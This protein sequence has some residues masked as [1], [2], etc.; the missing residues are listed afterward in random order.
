MGLSSQGAVQGD[1]GQRRQSAGGEVLIHCARA[2]LFAA[3]L[4]A[5]APALALSIPDHPDGPIND[6]AHVLSPEAK[7]RL[8]QQLLGYEQGTTRQIAVA[9]FPSL[10]DES[11]EDFTVRLAEKWK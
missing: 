7:A 3:L 10:D 1:H 8:E 11:M 5:A 2:S 9:I 6:F 4:L